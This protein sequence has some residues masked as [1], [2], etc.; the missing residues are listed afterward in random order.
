MF[1]CHLRK[2]LSN[3]NVKIFSTESRSR[4]LRSVR[5][6]SIF[7]PYRVTKKITRIT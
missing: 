3:C 5:A 4:R 6:L 1:L 7:L 2:D